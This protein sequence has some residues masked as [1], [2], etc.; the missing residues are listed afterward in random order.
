M[1]GTGENIKGQILPSSQEEEVSGQPYLVL[2]VR[3]ADAATR[4]D[5]IVGQINPDIARKMHE[6]NLRSYFGT[7]RINNCVLN[8]HGGMKRRRNLLDLVF[9][10]GGRIPKET[11]RKEEDDEE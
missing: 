7:D 6:K 10:T 4:V 3:G 8:V 2:V 1:I 5:Q 9:W 11:P